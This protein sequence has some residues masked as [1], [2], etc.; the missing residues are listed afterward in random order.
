[1]LNFQE[2]VD[3]VSNAL[4]N[5]P[6]SVSSALE[7]TA[8]AKLGSESVES[9]GDMSEVVEEGMTILQKVVKILSSIRF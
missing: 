7:V 2:L 4:T 6:N 1:M 9:M 8:A 5:G 3:Y